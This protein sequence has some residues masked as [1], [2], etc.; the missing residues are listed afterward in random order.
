M[1]LYPTA[2]IAV[3]LLKS[4]CTDLSYEFDLRC[5]PKELKRLAHAYA[6]MVGSAIR[7][8]K[9]G[10]VWRTKAILSDLNDL[11]IN[12]YFLDKSLER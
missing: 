10:E 5:V 1:K 3:S 2:N 9:A 7:W 6:E 11:A 12:W 8:H 4:L